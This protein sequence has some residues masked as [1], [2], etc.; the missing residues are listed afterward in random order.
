[1]ANCTILLIDYEPRSIERFRDPLVGAGYSVEIATDGI[2]GIEAFHRLNPD[3]VLVEA[4]IPKKHGFEVCQELKRTPHGRRTP[5]IITTGV[6]KG[7]KYRTQALHIYGCDEYIEK[8]IAPEQLLEIVGRFL[9]DAARA[10]GRAN[11]SAAA[12]S[13]AGGSPNFQ[14]HDESN[15]QAATPSEPAPHKPPRTTPSAQIGADDGEAEIMARLDAIIPTNELGS[16]AAERS[17]IAAS[18]AM[19]SFASSTLEDPLAQIRAELNA[20]LDSHLEML[21]L[22]DGESLDLIPSDHV[23]APSVLEALPIPPVVAEI[24]V[25]AVKVEPPRP[26]PAK[27][28]EARFTMPESPPRRGIPIWVWAIAAVVVGV[29]IYFFFTAS[30]GDAGHAKVSQLASAAPVTPVSAPTPTPTPTPTPAQAQAQTQ[31]VEP[32]KAPADNHKIVLNTPKVTVPVATK[33]APTPA[34]KHVTAS[35]VPPPSIPENT[36]ATSTPVAAAPAAPAPKKSA[37]A[38]AATPSSPDDNAGGVEALPNAANAVPSGGIAPGALVP[39]DEADVLPVNLTHK[40]PVYSP[41]TKELNLSGRIVMN[42]L[43]NEHGVV[44]QVVLVTGL[45]GGDVNDAAIHAAKSWTYRPATKRGV[46]VKVWRSE[47]VEVK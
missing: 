12:P 15:A 1:M 8:P 7:R 3:M 9:G 47:Q 41:Q 11:E 5:V 14:S 18:P 22:G 45:E 43:I 26:R 31:A 13:G 10:S 42:V 17:A 33:A 37:P 44:E 32:P 34:P 2:S 20:E 38:V 39:I 36:P 27:K 6:Y 21:D 40:A 16:S 4:M 46:P 19:E 25:P 35:V 24:P 30:S 29:G 23:E 28:T